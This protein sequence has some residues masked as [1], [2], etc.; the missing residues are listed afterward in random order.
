MNR[1]EFINY[2]KDT[3]ESF[4]FVYN[5][6]IIN[7]INDDYKDFCFDIPV[8]NFISHI[9]AIVKNTPFDGL[10]IN[11][12]LL[13]NYI[14]NA[15]MNPIYIRKDDGE[16]VEC[17]FISFNDVFELLQDKPIE[18]KTPIFR[19]EAGE[20]G[21]FHS[22][23]THRYFK[24]LELIIEHQEKNI[25]FL[26]QNKLDELAKAKELLET[27]NVETRYLSIVA[28]IIRELNITLPEHYDFLECDDKGVIS[29]TEDGA[30]SSVFSS[31]SHSYHR[32]WFFGFE[33]HELLLKWINN[34]GIG[35]LLHEINAEIKVYYSDEVI[36]TSNQMIFKKQESVKTLKMF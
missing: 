11:T 17:T 30:I 7:P 34:S 36:K 33:S 16:Q 26:S 20:Q 28:T 35:N 9:K 13:S 27:K 18:D 23:I 12:D 14:E 19:L 29:P 10:E 4:D 31:W 3:S 22:L 32:E 15:Y 1:T 6:L 21:L 25:N 24:S 8:I 2:L 5:Y